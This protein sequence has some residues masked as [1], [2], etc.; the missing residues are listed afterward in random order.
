MSAAWPDLLDL[1]DEL[2]QRSAAPAAAL[3]KAAASVA[4]SAD[5]G[6]Y[7]HP[8]RKEA[9]V[10]LRGS[11]AHE[12]AELAA[13]R[14]AAA[15]VAKVAEFDDDPLWI[16]LAYS[17]TLATAGEWLN[18]FP[19]TYPGGIPNHPS[20]LAALLTSSLL[21]AGVGYGLGHLTKAVL[22]RRTG[23]K[24]PRTGAIAGALAGAVPGA[25][26]AYGNAR[27]G[28]TL[29]EPWP[30]VPVHKE[31]IDKLADD[32]D[33]TF[34]DLPSGPSPLDVNINRLGQVLWDNNASDELMGA[35]VGTIYA[36]KQMPDPDARPGWVTG[37]QL[38]EL[39]VRAGK[40]YLTGALV[41]AALNATVGTP[42]SAPALGAGAASLGVI[43]TV[44]SK[45]F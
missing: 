39:A 42:W 44:L 34:P 2:T 41:G 38:G 27:S 13:A 40:D 11:L 20:P 30:F 37:R 14:Q 3:R 36:A 12:A 24:L 32:L 31:A 6:Y 8:Q 9:A 33:S 35:A 16:K 25:L 28:H 22:P 21:G 15:A 7:Y 19:G 17:P 26:W 1:V 29:T 5:V 10:V 18:F 43:Q 4:T 23:G 45:L